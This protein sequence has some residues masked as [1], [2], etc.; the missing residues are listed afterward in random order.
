MTGGPLA[1]LLVADFSELLPGPFLTQ[2]LADL[3]ARVVKIERPGDDN[4]RHL[5][6]GLFAAVNRGKEHRTADLKD[7]AQRAEVEELVAGAD[8]L[9]EGFRPG[10]MASLGFDPARTLA[11]NPRLVYVSISGFGQAGPLSREP[12]HD[13]TYAAY[14]GV[15][16]LAGTPGVPMADLCAAMYG[17]SALLAALHERARTGRGRHLD[18]SI[19]DCLAHW[20]NVRLGPFHHAGLTDVEDQRALLLRR[21][22]YGVFTCADGKAVAVAAIEDHFFARLVQ[23]LDLTEWADPRWSAYR[24]RNQAAEEINTAMAAALATRDSAQA[25]ET[26]TKAGVPAAPVLTPLEALAVSPATFTT[27]EAGTLHAWPVPMT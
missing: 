16:A 5:S 15:L 27:P 21:A 20:M 18:V 26:L 14:T 22:G 17:M 8:V 12:G 19:R 23:A 6:P 25:L 4:A 7:P 11:A 10:V 9:V 1:G 3:G 13:I 24:A 2:N